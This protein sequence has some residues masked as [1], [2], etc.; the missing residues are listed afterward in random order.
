MRLKNLKCVYVVIFFILFLA[1]KKEELPIPPKALTLSIEPSE[2]KLAKEEPYGERL[3]L[4]FQNYEYEPGE[5]LSFV[6]SSENPR[7][8][9]VDT[10]GVVWPEGAG[11]T[12][13]IAKLINGKAQARCKVT[14]TDGYDYKYRLVLKDKGT[15]DL[16]LNSPGAFLSAKAIERRRKQDIEVNETDLPIS[17]DYL[18]IIQQ[19]GGKIVAKSKWLS[20]VSVHCQ[21]QFLID[22]YK[23]L[24]FVK[25]VVLVWEG[26]RS[27]SSSTEKYKDIPQVGS[28]ATDNTNPLD[29]GTARNNISVNNG[30]YLHD[31]GYRGAG[32]DIAVIDAGFIN[33]KNNAGFKSV[34]IKGAKSFI[35]ENDDPYSVDSHGVWVTSCLAANV[36]GYYVGTAPEANY[37]L[38]R[39]EDQSSEYPIE[40][41]YW[42]NA[43]EYADSAGVDIINSSLYYSTGYTFPSIV[44]SFKDMDGKTAMASRAANVAASKGILIV[45]C[46][47]N[48]QSWVGTPA[49]SP[50]VLTVGSVHKSLEADSFTSY[51]ITVDNR[52]K[53]DVMALGGGA[54]VMNVLGESEFRFGTSYASPILCGLAACLWQAYPKLTNLELIDIIRKSGDRASHPVVPYGYGIANME[55]ASALARARGK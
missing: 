9:R 15:T 22:Q 16:N 2:V 11:E 43:A 12:Y 29:Y 32:I 41:D 44:Y 36:P 45:N 37:W 14:I 24:P 1:C 21:D 5:D 53:P 10:N 50:N 13:V 8:A 51:G 27:E 3:K 33:L 52:I 6:W 28:V 54:A 17:A 4:T 40:E 39:T 7:I 20:T 48:E 55:T 49:D 25:E 42:V 35:F 47:G 23:A 18:R 31:K 26:K 46:A 30:Q 38:L 19:V 34:N